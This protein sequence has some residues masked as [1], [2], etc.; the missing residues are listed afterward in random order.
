MN[1]KM[2]KKTG[3]TEETNPRHEEWKEK[4]GASLQGRKKKVRESN[5]TINLIC[6]KS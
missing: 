6:S 2:R 5:C 1:E 3:I 4:R